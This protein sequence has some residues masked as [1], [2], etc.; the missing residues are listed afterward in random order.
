MTEGGF[1]SDNTIY[2]LS[3]F[4]KTA[5]CCYLALY[6]GYFG[7]LSPAQYYTVSA[8]YTVTFFSSMPPASE[9]AVGS[10]LLRTKKIW[11]ISIMN[12]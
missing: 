4:Y 5:H 2:H 11:S 3:T 8:L 10:S 12:T 7:V 1:V 6:I 9:Q